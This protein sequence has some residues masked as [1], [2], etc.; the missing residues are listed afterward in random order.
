MKILESQ[1]GITLIEVVIAAGLIGF[2]GII[3][4]DILI[5]HQSLFNEENLN[6]EIISE[7]KR[8]LKDISNSVR[9]ASDVLVSYTIGAD[10]YQ[11]NDQSLVLKIP[12]VD[13]NGNTIFGSYDHIVFFI[14]A[15]NS[16]KL[17]KKTLVAT[18]SSR[19]N[20]EISQT[21]SLSDLK[22]EFNTPLVE[23]STL[24]KTELEIQKSSFGKTKA[25]RDQIESNLR[26][27]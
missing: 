1:K 27:D 20:S 12:S 7:N 22:F 3:L 16:H 17:I 15:L 23:D 25:F 14:D 10:T 6:M 11:T 19:Q 13:N 9:N 8:V 18:G 21:L 2:L 26:N 24:I 4:G 5:N